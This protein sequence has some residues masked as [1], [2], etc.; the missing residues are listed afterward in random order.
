M[1]KWKTGKIKLGTD[2]LRELV[3]NK[4]IALM[5]NHTALD[6]DV[7]DLVDVMFY[8]WKCNIA[9]LFGM[10]HGVRGNLYAGEH[11]I[12]QVDH[13]TGLK[14][15]NLYNYPERRPPV[16]FVSEVDAVVFCSQ[17]SGVRHWTWN[18]G[19]IYLIDSAA[20]T[21]TEVIILDRPNPLNGT[22]VEG[23][24]T[25]EGYFSAVGP[26]PYPLRHGMTIGELAT[27]YNEEYAVN[28]NLTVIKM[29]GWDRS[30]YYDDTGLFYVPLTS[31]LPSVESLIGYSTTGL[32]QNTNVSYGRGTML[33]YQIIGAPWINGQDLAEKLNRLDMPGIFFKEIYFK[34]NF[35]NYAGELCYGVIFKCYDRKK[36]SPVMAIIN[37]LTFMV[38]DYGDKFK[39]DEKPYDRR[40]GSR[41]LRESLLS[42]I[43]AQEIIDNWKKQTDVFYERRRKYLMY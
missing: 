37:I 3:V 30:M 18:A 8:D 23:N 4:K 17:D 36:Y 40:V 5:M 13:K 2:K 31:N 38:E 22:A 15:I 42:G 24:V 12:E 25:E 32:L 20:K 21:G 9:F 33:P 16:E 10:E 7:K 29:E 26:Y 11:S 6:N 41:Y 28:C 1:Q 35:F 34:P 14:V 39:F 27:M 19:M 43:S